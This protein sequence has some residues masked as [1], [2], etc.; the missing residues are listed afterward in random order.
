[1]AEL[2]QMEMPFEETVP[3]VAGSATSRAAARHLRATGKAAN[4]EADALWLFV[5]YPDGLTD[6][7]LDALGRSL[8]LKFTTLR[9]RRV[10]L[11]QKGHLEDSAQRRRTHSGREAT[12]WRITAEGR[13]VY[14]GAVAEVEQEAG[15]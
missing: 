5:L 3:Y 11:F 7:E 10:A 1:M 9:P 12:V 13:R 4:L 14:R 2:Q 8:R 6:L 15:L